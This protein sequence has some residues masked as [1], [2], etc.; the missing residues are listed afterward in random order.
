[1]DFDRKGYKV[2]ALEFDGG[3]ISI[4]RIASDTLLTIKTGC[5][6][7]LYDGS[8]WIGGNRICI[9]DAYP[10]RFYFHIN[11]DYDYGG[12]VWSD[13]RVVMAIYGISKIN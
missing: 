2:Y 11:A 13:G 6:N 4:V 7:S 8:K 12:G 3:I 10:N 5:V 9:F 1:M